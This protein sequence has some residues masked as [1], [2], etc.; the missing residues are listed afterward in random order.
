[1]RGRLCKASKRCG[2][3]KPGGAAHRGLQQLSTRGTALIHPAPLL[4]AHIPPANARSRAIGPP[5]F[6]GLGTLSRIH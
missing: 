1:L 6:I 4:P 5:D 2:Q 3:Y